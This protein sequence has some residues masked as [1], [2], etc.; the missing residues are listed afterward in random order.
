MGKNK[1]IHVDL[2]FLSFSFP[3]TNLPPFN[4]KYV[5]NVFID[6]TIIVIISYKSGILDHLILLVME[7]EKYLTGKCLTY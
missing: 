2:G 6:D 5:R 4:L 1:I 7:T 3:P